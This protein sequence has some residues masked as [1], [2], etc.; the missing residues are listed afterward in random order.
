M[1]RHDRRQWLFRVADVLSAPTF[2]VE[3]VMGVASVAAIV[4]LVLQLERK[5]ATGKDWL[6]TWFFLIFGA[7]W[8]V[9]APWYGRSIA[10]L[11]G[12]TFDTTSEERAQDER[13]SRGLAR[14]M[15]C[16]LVAVGGWRLLGW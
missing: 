2:V 8:L 9:L 6:S 7:L 5:S 16:A 13:W 14:V 3:V 1:N 10:E 4:A 11:H 15:G 12:R